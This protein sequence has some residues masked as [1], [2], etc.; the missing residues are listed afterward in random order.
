[1]GLMQLNELGLNKIEMAVEIIRQNATEPYFVC[2][3]GGKDSNVVVDL[4]MNQAK[5]PADYHYNVSP[6]DPPQVYKFLKEFHPFTQWDLHAKDFWQKVDKKGLP[7]R[8][9]RW[10]CEIIKEGGGSGR[11]VVTGVRWA[12]SSKRACRRM[13]EPDKHDKTK[14]Y[15]HPIICWTDVEV[16]EY[17]HKYNL[18]Y[19]PLYDNGWKRIGCIGCPI[20]GAKTQRRELLA[21]PETAY[22]WKV[23]ATNFFNTH[24][25]SVEMYETPDNFWNWWLSGKSVKNYL[26]KSQS[27][28]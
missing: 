22:K 27:K 24:P 12:E 11:I 18:P 14:R 6:I 28:F 2:D 7:T 16:W 20:A 10:C 15:L 3:S 26:N 8:T 25:E 23:H 21:Y 1:M 19:N 9:R 5:V 13:L 4:I 17:I